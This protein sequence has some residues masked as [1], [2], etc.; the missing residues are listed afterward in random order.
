MES[1][2]GISQVPG[3]TI[4]PH[5]TADNFVIGETNLVIDSKWSAPSCGGDQLVPARRRVQE[6][7]ATSQGQ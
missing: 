3:G 6:L 4:F 5:A 7:G 1:W 2:G